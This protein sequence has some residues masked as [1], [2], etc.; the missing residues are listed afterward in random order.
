MGI[1]TVEK[2]VMNKTP[3]NGT[4]LFCFTIK[5]GDNENTFNIPNHEYN[6]DGV[7]IPTNLQLSDVNVGDKVTFEMGLDDDQAD[8]CSGQ[9][10]DKCSGSW[11][12][13]NRGAKKMNP[14]PDWQFIIHYSL[15]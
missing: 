9:A 2:I 11:T 8:V 14:T 3:Q 15:T 6:G 4:W 12:V 10:E 13:V 7:E 1:L 5:K